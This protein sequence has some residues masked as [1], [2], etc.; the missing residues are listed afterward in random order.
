MSEK[1]AAAIA[2]DHRHE[3][4]AQKSTDPD[5]VPSR[6]GTRDLGTAPASERISKHDLPPPPA[7]VVSALAAFETAAPESFRIGP[8]STAAHTVG[9][10]DPTA[11]TV[12]R[13]HE[14]SEV[15]I[16]G[17][18]R[19]LKIGGIAAASVILVGTVWALLSK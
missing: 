19:K 5:E 14:N 2:T 10:Q 1:R 18:S 11:A 3:T 6:S 17:S 4:L 15:S 12:L 13:I 7:Q 8:K 16:S 9:A